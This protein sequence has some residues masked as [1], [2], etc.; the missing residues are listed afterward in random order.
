MPEFVIDRER[1]QRL[2]EDEDAQVVD[3]LPRPEYEYAHLPGAI[4]V[5]LKSFDPSG[6]DRERPVVVYCNDFL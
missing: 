2:I 5:P 1:I 4:H 6:L 3:V